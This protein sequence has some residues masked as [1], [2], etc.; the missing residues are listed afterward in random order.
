MGIALKKVPANAGA[1]ANGDMQCSLKTKSAMENKP[2]IE[3]YSESDVETEV[4]GQV[5]EILAK[6]K[7]KGVSPQWG[8]KEHVALIKNLAL[9]FQIPDDQ[10]ENFIKCLLF[11]GIGGNAAQFRQWK[12]LADALPKKLDL[13]IDLGY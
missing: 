8:V 4:K 1:D 7:A 10:V 11:K 2:K 5:E 9:G 6:Q 13:A 3:G 12:H